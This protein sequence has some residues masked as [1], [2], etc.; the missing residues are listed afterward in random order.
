MPD[1]A[2]NDGASNEAEAYVLE[3]AYQP[4]G[5]SQDQVYEMAPHLKQVH[6]NAT[7][8]K[9]RVAKEDIY[10]VA[11]SGKSLRVY[12]HLALR[13]PRAVGQRSP[14]RRGGAVTARSNHSPASR[15]PSNRAS[16]DT[17]R[18]FST[19]DE[20]DEEVAA[21]AKAAEDAKAAL[22]MI[23]APKETEA[24]DAESQR[25]LRLPGETRTVE[26]KPVKWYRASGFGPEMPDL[27][28]E[29]GRTVPPTRCKTGGAETTQKRR[30]KAK[31]DLNEIF[32]GGSSINRGYRGGHQYRDYN[33]YYELQRRVRQSDNRKSHC[34]AG[35]T[36][37]QLL[38]SRKHCIKDVATD[39][40]EADLQ[41]AEKV[42][43]SEQQ[44]KKLEERRLKE[45]EKRERRSNAVQDSGMKQVMQEYAGLPKERMDN[46][47]ILAPTKVR[48]VATPEYAARVLNGKCSWNEK[49]MIRN[50][51]RITRLSDQ[52]KLQ[53][54]LL[55]KQKRETV[56]TRLRQYD[57]KHH[58]LVHQLEADLDQQ[59]RDR[60]T[61]LKSKLTAVNESMDDDSMNDDAHPSRG[62]TLNVTLKAMRLKSLNTLTSEKL[63]VHIKHP[64]YFELVTLL[65]TSETSV[66]S[67]AE[68]A[69]IANLK[70]SAETQGELTV[71]VIGDTL[72]PSQGI[73][74]NREG[75]RVILETCLT[76]LGFK[77]GSDEAGLQYDRLAKRVHTVAKP[78]FSTSL[79]NVLHSVAAL[80]SHISANAVSTPNI[81]PMLGPSIGPATP[82]PEVLDGTLK[83]E[84]RLN[85]RHGSFFITG[86]D[87]VQ[88]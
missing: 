81:S 76:Y 44:K 27:R 33:G 13:P 37:F 77:T 22:A 56:N 4:L 31:D 86:G 9:T 80:T 8:K 14:A 61:S 84:L 25:S 78:Q 55:A 16:P 47:I 41:S 39:W 68:E 53:S 28:P 66:F 70:L 45:L 1:A 82:P 35:S 73:D 51:D 40:L 64:W 71:D 2:K 26:G 21:A 59:D 48:D 52:L 15:S 30:F 85:R 12:K 6:L 65:N 24:A 5:L 54:D 36:V 62:P 18:L 67:K 7:K 23:T 3:H 17:A 10:P 19:R 42:V 83:E 72:E 29:A 74:I 49:Q 88:E 57:Q 58:K 60:F 11:N 75:F 20:E 87:F 50:D 69:L 79:A 46:L 38:K 34:F 32:E 43:E 63:A